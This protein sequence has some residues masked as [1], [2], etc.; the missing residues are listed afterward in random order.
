MFQRCVGSQTTT[1]TTYS[2]WYFCSN[3]Y[4]AISVIFATIL[5]VFSIFPQVLLV[6]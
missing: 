2:F 3:Q 6:K 1:T 5:V 4:K